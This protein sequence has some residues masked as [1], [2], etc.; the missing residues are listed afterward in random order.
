MQLKKGDSG[1]RVEKLQTTLR[2]LGYLARPVSGE[3][4]GNTQSAVK[5]FQKQLKL[6]QDGIAGEK[7][8][9]ALYKKNAPKC[10]GYITLKKGDSG[11]RVKEM[12]N[13][14]RKL[15]FMT[16]KAN[17][18]YDNTTVKAVKAY[19]DAANLK[20]NGKT[21]E[22]SVIKGMFSYVKPTDKPTEAP[23]DKPTEAPTD[24]PTEEPE[25]KPTEEPEVKPTEEPEVKPTEEPEVKPNRRARGEAHRG[26]RGEAH[27]G[28]RSEAHRGARSEA[29]RG[30]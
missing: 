17:S 10:K 28:A 21:A 14:L 8:L 22:A 29:H 25:V 19:L 23:T 2:K 3:F 12:Q 18:R 7:T 6:K 27:R 9:K 13:Q 16:K 11:I 15:G 1:I 30:A 5:R 26:A 4:D 20:G 24:K